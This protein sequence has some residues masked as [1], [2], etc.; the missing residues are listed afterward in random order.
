MR[1]KERMKELLTDF[2]TFY[3]KNDDIVLIVA[4]IKVQRE[5]LWIEQALL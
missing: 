1:Q 2:N 3:D 4:Q 5:P